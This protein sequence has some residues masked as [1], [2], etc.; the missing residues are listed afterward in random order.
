MCHGWYK[1]WNWDLTQGWI[2][3][4]IWIE[5]VMPFTVPPWIYY[6]NGCP[7]P[8]LYHCSH[9][10]KSWSP[11]E[12]LIWHTGMWYLSF[13]GLAYQSQASTQLPFLFW[14]G[15]FSCL[16]EQMDF[17]KFLTCLIFFFFFI[18]LSSNA[19]IKQC[20]IHIYSIS[21]LGYHTII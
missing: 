11:L 13:I 21:N 3:G 17:R 9:I 12:R 14:D 1:Q 18:L 8:H 20:N 15:A 10:L 5:N 7:I 19:I 16:W 4:W 6:I 2:Q